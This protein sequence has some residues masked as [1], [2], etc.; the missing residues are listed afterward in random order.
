M[1]Q[2][3]IFQPCSGYSVH[4]CPTNGGSQLALSSLQASILSDLHQDE[5]TS[6]HPRPE[7]PLSES[8][9]AGAGEDA[10]SHDAASNSAGLPSPFDSSGVSQVCLAASQ[11]SIW[12]VKILLSTLLQ[13]KLAIASSSLV[14]R[15]RFCQLM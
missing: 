12:V 6:R 5:L 8:T 10:G 11:K 4:L 7:S 2:M 9:F 14:A 1:Q 13:P 15:C 3:L